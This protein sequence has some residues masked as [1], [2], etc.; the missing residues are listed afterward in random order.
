[1]ATGLHIAYR[2]ELK[3]VVGEPSIHLLRLARLF[4]A[5]RDL[6]VLRQQLDLGSISARKF[7]RR[8]MQSPSFRLIL[9][10]EPG[11]R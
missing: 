6:S 5:D 1:L 10:L 2:T 11:R 7:R 3:F 4:E 9:L 8:L